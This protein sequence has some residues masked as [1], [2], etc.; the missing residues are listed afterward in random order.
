[1]MFMTYGPFHYERQTS[2]ETIRL[3]ESM[4]AVDAELHK[5][6]GIY[7]FAGKA[8]AGHLVPLYV[9]KA[10]RHGVGARIFRHLDNGKFVSLIQSCRGICVFL[11]AATGPDGHLRS[12]QSLSPDE[13]E[14]IGRLEWSL[15]GSA[16]AQSASLL[17]KH[18]RKSPPY[19]FNDNEMGCGA[20][21]GS[22]QQVTDLLGLK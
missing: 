20:P 5:A 10:S 9:G 2:L 19:I 7:V 12:K 17:N 14:Q 18:G 13:H 8:Q 15:I 11:L 3:F 21:V 1:M 6:V 4:A 16:A 22:L